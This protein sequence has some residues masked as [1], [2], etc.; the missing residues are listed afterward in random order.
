MLEFLQND[1]QTRTQELHRARSSEIACAEMVRRLES[2]VQELANRLAMASASQ[3]EQSQPPSL[4]QHTGRTEVVSLKVETGKLKAQ[5]QE[6][7]DLLAASH[8]EVRELETQN[9]SLKAAL[10]AATARRTCSD[11]CRRN[12]ALVALYERQTRILRREGENLNDQIA[13]Y[14]K[15]EF[16]ANAL[17]QANVEQAVL[18]N[19][20]AGMTAKLGL[21]RKEVEDKDVELLEKEEELRR[22]REEL[23]RR[24]EM[25]DRYVEEVQCFRRQMDAKV[26]FLTNELELKDIKIR[27]LQGVP[28][29]QPQPAFKKKKAPRHPYVFESETESEE[30]SELVKFVGNDA[31]RSAVR[32]LKAAEQGSDGPSDSGERPENNI[33]SDGNEYEPLL[34]P[35][36]PSEE[37]SSPAGKVHSPI[38]ESAYASDA[39]RRDADIDGDAEDVN[40]DGAN[41]NSPGSNA[42]ETPSPPEDKSDSSPISVGDLVKGLRPTADD[43]D[44]EDADDE[45]ERELNGD[46]AE[47]MFGGEY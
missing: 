2:Q 4:R 1:L 34:D 10:D 37:D 31:V 47:H 18:I 44:D 3:S 35:I 6:T 12:E 23:E 43:D 7:R 29:E 25:H 19:E 36:S 21:A 9:D 26:E 5:L 13:E 46:P 16:L 38:T 20:R 14:Q 15:G 42:D 45:D 17:G 8:E 40:S 33:D 41:S 11:V 30:A 24:T 32:A 22:T 27:E 39:V 28:E